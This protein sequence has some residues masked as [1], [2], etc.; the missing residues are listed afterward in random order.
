M[1]EQTA[2]GKWMAVKRTSNGVKMSYFDTEEE[3]EAYEEG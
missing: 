3:A 2:S 1:A